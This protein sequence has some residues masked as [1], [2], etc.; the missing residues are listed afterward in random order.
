M[1]SLLESKPASPT[2]CTFNGADASAFYR[3]NQRLFVAIQN[4]FSSSL[5]LMSRPSIA[6]V[7]PR[8]GTRTN[9]SCS[10][11][12]HRPPCC[13]EQQ[14]ARLDRGR[15]HVLCG[16]EPTPAAWNRWQRETRW[17]I[18]FLFEQVLQSNS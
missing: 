12:C 2:T 16:C 11:A 3:W 6:I 4:I 18:S 9:W 8:P 13:L 15:G 10:H 5:P 17:V 1:E 14:P 7:Q